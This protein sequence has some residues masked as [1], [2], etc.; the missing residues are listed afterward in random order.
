MTESLRLGLALVAGLGLGTLFFYG[1]WRTVQH[2]L[3][4]RHPALWLLGSLLLRLGLA[5]LGFY[6]VGQGSWPRLLACLAGF[7]AARY[8]VAYFTRPAAASTPAGPTTPPR[9]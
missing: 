1:L 9:S 3:T 2:S 7:V 8:G 4:A 6:Y 5:M